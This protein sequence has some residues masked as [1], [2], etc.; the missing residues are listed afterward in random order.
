MFLGMPPNLTGDARADNAALR[1]YLFKL[2]QS[3]ETVASAQST[4]LSTTRDAQGRTVV[5]AAPSTDKTIKEISKN[6]NELKALIIKSAEEAEAYT[7]SKTEVYNGMYVAQSEYGLFQET[8]EAR[9][10][11][12]AAGVVESYNYAG[13][14]NSMQ[15]SIGLLQTYVRNIDGEIRR[16]I[17]MDPETGEYVTGI[18]ISQRLS[19]DG[20]C[21][22]TDAHNPGDGYTYYYL[23]QGQT[24]GLYTS[25]GWQFWIDGTKRGWFN[26][27]DGMLHVANVLVEDTLQISDSW[28]VKVTS[29]MLEFAYLE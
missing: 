16:G 9:I 20:E 13:R 24:F 5:S 8:L 1:D 6:A 3:L 4:V 17:V 28:Q 26:S 15:D 19:F 11:N 29:G 12:T 14:I 27:V 18:A 2:A 25:T 10:V 7:D 23:T 21:G 22:P